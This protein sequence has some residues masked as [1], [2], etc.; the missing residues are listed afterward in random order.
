MVACITD[1]CYTS[2]I[3]HHD[4]LQKRG[5]VMKIKCLLGLIAVG[6]FCATSFAICFAQS[7]Y[8]TVIDKRDTTLIV[9]C[10]DGSTRTV[11]AGGISGLYRQGD[12]IDASNPSDPRTLTS[13]QTRPVS[14][15][16]RTG[17]SDEIRYFGR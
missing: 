17:P 16:P 10:P 14:P 8:C 2:F 1:R 7:I 9:S 11:N 15:N 5:M 12:L 13:R 3:M 6:V 4:C